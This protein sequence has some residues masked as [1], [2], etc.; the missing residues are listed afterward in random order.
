MST[1]FWCSVGLS[2]LVLASAQGA[3]QSEDLGD[4]PLPRKLPTGVILV[5]GAWSSASDSITPV[6][7]GGQVINNAYT[8]KYFGL[9]YPLSSDWTEKYSG[10]P[11]SDSG[12]YVLAQIRPADTFNGPTHGTILIA[13]QDLFFSLTPAQNALEMVH[14]TEEHLEAGYQVER[15]PTEIRISG[16]SFVRLDYG[17]PVAALHWRVLATDIRCH[18]VEF[19]FTSRDVDLAEALIRQMNKMALPPEADLTPG[20]DAGDAPVCL[21]DYATGS[22]VIK[23]VNPVFAEHRFNPVPVRIIIDREGKVRHIHFLS[24]FPDQAKAIADALS[25]WRVKPYQRDGRS[26]EVETG[27]MFGRAPHL[28]T[29]TNR[30]VE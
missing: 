10:P 9:T 18:T 23:K 27:I 15:P 11:P 6:P 24:A 19:V 12:Y 13:A 20:M 22:N 7:E 1:R 4:T 5:K 14:Y 26:L 25:Q 3:P 29:P 30:A 28:Q 2:L 8:N 17:S 21:K 16:H